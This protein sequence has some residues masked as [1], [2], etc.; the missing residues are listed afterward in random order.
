METWVPKFYIILNRVHESTDKISNI[1]VCA[2]LNDAKE[3]KI[4]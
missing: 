1:K 3:N 4:S 2:T